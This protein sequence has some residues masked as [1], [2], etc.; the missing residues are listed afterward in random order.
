MADKISPDQLLELRSATQAVSQSVSARLRFHLEALASLFRPRRFLGDHI[1][2]PSREAA[3]GADKNAAELKE[4]Y[5]RVAIKPFDLRPELST[6]L[7]SVAT[8]FHLHPWEY[9]H[10]IETTGRGWQT[11]RITTPLTWVLTYAS[12]YSPAVLRDVIDGSAQRD[13]EAV[14]A[15]VF[16]A[17][18][19]HELFR[20]TPSIGDILTALRYKVEIRK[21][22]QFG[23]LPLV[24]IASPFRTFR[25]PDDLVMLAAGM[26]GGQTFA[27]VLDLDSV[28]SLSDPLKEDALRILNR[29]QHHPGQAGSEA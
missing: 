15:F 9:P 24:T 22:P 2:A 1:E 10:P 23:E 26:A 19:M 8:Q 18:V 27:E 20:T 3:S 7:E 17:C 6:P 13:T 25:P 5:R 16:R 12:P 21:L 4:L 28:N 11:I 29:N 14:R